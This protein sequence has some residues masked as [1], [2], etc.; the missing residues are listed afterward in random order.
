MRALPDTSLTPRN[1]NRAP[2]CGGTLSLLS[3]CV[4]PSRV[5][6]DMK[7]T[8]PEP[9]LSTSG[10]P[11]AILAPRILLLLS[12]PLPTALLL[13]SGFLTRFRTL[14]AGILV[15]TAHSG[16]P[17]FERRA[18]LTQELPLRCMKSVGSDRFIPW[19]P[20]VATVA[21]GTPLPKKAGEARIC[22]TAR[23]CR[24][25]FLTVSNCANVVLRLP[26]DA[27]L[28]PRCEQT[29]GGPW[30]ILRS[31]SLTASFSVRSTA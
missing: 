5:I 6:R 29:I 22:G 20:C 21:N 23:C 18:G 17:F 13:L 7:L 19:P 16:S 4:S 14:L 11:L 25:R 24:P 27:G 15:L 1:T 2:L 31:N 28:L 3:L 8:Q 26:S 30:I 12:G 9:A 10:F